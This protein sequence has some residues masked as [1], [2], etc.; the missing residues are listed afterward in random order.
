MVTDRLDGNMFTSG[1]FNSSQICNGMGSVKNDTLQFLI[2]V[3]IPQW[4]LVPNYIVVELLYRWNI[5]LVKEEE[6]GC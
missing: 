1:K 2:G 5:I 4:K 3:L 6:H